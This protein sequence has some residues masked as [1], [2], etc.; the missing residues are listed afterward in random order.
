MKKSLQT[1]LKHLVG[2]LDI[3]KLD[4]EKFAKEC[5]EMKALG[6]YGVYFN[7]IFFTI[8]NIDYSCPD[9]DILFR[10]DECLIVRRSQN[11]LAQIKNILQKYDL[12]TP[13]AHFPAVLSSPGANLESIYGTHEKILNIALF[14]ELKRVTTHVGHIAVPVDSTLPGELRCGKLNYTEYCE[15]LK[16]SYGKDK[17]I[18]DSL[19]IY[20]QLCK[21]AAKRNITVTIETACCELFEITMKPE[22]IID[23]I[24]QV[25]TDNLKIC[26]DAGH[27]HCAGLDVAEIIRKCGSYF[28]ETHFHDNFGQKDRHNPIGIG[29]INWLEVIKAM[30]ENDYQ[31]V[32]T[33]EQHDYLTNY[34]NWNLFIKQ[35]EK[36]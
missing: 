1:G 12:K 2:T 13:S 11:E 32:I 23:F 29:T 16:I 10:E 3:G 26:I 15:Q 19:I 9:E 17:I 5:A 7:D 14:M 28:V 4:I 20:R 6:Y 22:T 31:G 8:E 35:V 25:G 18:P 34:R 33:F 27:C 36:E 30:N 21:E 24:K